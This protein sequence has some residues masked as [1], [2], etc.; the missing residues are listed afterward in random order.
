MGF[1]FFSELGSLQ[2]VFEQS[3]FF[4]K[5]HSG[6]HVKN[7]VEG[8]KSEGTETS[9]ANARIQKRENSSRWET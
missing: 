3:D 5:Y 8:S 7:R 4:V 1:G 6:S 2:R 9:W